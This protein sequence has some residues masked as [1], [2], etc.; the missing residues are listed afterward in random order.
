M[1]IF[2]I[3]LGS[4]SKL[5]NYHNVLVIAGC[6]SSFDTYPKTVLADKFDSLLSQSIA[7][8]I[9]T[10]LCSYVNWVCIILFIWVNTWLLLKLI[11]FLFWMYCDFHVSQF[12]MMESVEVRNVK[13]I[14]WKQRH[15]LLNGCPWLYL[16]FKMVKKGAFLEDRTSFY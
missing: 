1:I 10:F 8:E 4:H 12:L 15:S 9:V 13:Q 2:I 14:Q 5:F 6:D 11:L 7:L 3:K 16:N